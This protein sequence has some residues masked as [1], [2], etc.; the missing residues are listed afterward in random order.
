MVLLS[1]PPQPKAGTLL[2]HTYREEEGKPGL[3]KL[4]ISLHRK[5][6]VNESK[7]PRQMH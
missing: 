1:P 3:S 6:R 2:R 5:R 7:L 4:L